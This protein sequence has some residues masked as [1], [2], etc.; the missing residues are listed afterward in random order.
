[1]SSSITKWSYTSRD[2]EL[3]AIRWYLTGRLDQQ[4]EL[5]LE[6]GAAV[7]AYEH[8]RHVVNRMRIHS[9]DSQIKVDPAEDFQSGR[10]LSR[11]KGQTGGGIVMVLENNPSH[12]FSVRE[13]RHFDAVH[14]ARNAIRIGMD[15]NI[16]GP[17]EQSGNIVRVG[18]RSST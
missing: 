1:M 7:N 16:D 11:K 2:G 14:A 15:V 9:A 3:E 5:D 6:W 10:L 4:T 13:L 12:S 8:L 18:F 17:S